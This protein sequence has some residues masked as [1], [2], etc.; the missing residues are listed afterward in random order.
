MGSSRSPSVQTSCRPPLRR[1]RQPHS[2]KRC[3][4]SRRFTGTVYTDTCAI[5]PVSGSPP[6]SAAATDGNRC[7]MS[8]QCA[9]LARAV[10]AA[11]RQ[12]V[13][14]TYEGPRNTRRRPYFCS[15][16]AA[17]VTRCAGPRRFRRMGL[18]FRPLELSTS[19]ATRVLDRSTN[20]RV[21]RRSP[22]GSSKRNYH[23]CGRA[24]PG[25]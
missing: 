10:A 7:H 17:H 8:A 22:H 1:N 14:R 24:L 15:N 3:S 19:R 20:R 25:S 11:E 9:T 6:N 18:G 16:P 5:I 2:A 13:S 12:N 21:G 4:R 23:A